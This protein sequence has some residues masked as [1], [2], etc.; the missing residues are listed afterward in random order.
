MIYRSYADIASGHDMEQP[1]VRH[2]GMVFWLTGLSAAGKTSLA[3]GVAGQLLTRGLPAAVLDGDIMRRG[4]CSDLGFSE[5]DRW[6]NNRR[7]AE[8]ARLMALTGGQIC[9]CAFITPLES[10]RRAVRDIVT[11]RHFREIYVDC[12]LQTCI[13]RD[14]KGNYAKALRGGMRGYTGIDAPFEAP[15][16]PDFTVRT[17]DEPLDASVNRL[18]A[19]VL[20]QTV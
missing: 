20:A 5:K 4:L 1:L 16:M 8:V 13:R 15:L 10:M 17:A 9:L 18:L 12:D 2:S 7:C 3:N 19:Y 14:P 11:E 6:E